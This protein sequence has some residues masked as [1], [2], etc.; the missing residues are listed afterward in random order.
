MRLSISQAVVHCQSRIRQIVL[1]PLFNIGLGCIS[2]WLGWI[3]TVTEDMV[4]IVLEVTEDTVATVMALA[5]NMFRNSSVEFH[6]A[7]P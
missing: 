3:P 6:F 7:M 2:K 5:S 4:D 1:F